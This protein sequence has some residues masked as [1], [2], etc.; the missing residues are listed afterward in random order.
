MTASNLTEI[1][2]R[3]LEQLRA[4]EN[5]S[6]VLARYPANADE[7]APLLE[8]AQALDVLR[9]VEARAPETVRARRARFL[10]KAWLKRK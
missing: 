4:G 2:D 8:A 6:A 9:P 3:A 7:L 10:A 5:L 1:V